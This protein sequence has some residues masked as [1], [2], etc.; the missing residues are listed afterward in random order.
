[1]ADHVL[2]NR[3]AWDRWAPQY[4]VA[5]LRNWAA[6]EPSWGIWGIPEAQA[7]ILPPGLALRRSLEGPQTLNLPHAAAL[8]GQPP[9]SASTAASSLSRNPDCTVRLSA[10]RLQ[11]TCLRLSAAHLS[12]QPRTGMRATTGAP[13]SPSRLA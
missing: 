6:D 4:A 13:G 5:G 9:A 10:A 2:S 12:H 7:Q 11:V 1:M 8:S 3:S